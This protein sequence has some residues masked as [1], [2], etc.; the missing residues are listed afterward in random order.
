MAQQS[1][2]PAAVGAL[3]FDWLKRQVDGWQARGLVSPD[4]AS[5]ILAGY[6]PVGRFSAA[7]AA[8]GLTGLA[9]LMAA[10]A[11]LLVIG[12][13]WEALAPAAR[14]AIVFGFVGGAFAASALAYRRAR[15]WLGEALAFAATLLYGNGIFLLAGVFHIRTHDPDGLFWWMAGTLVTAVLLESRLIAITAMALLLVWV[16]YEGAEYA[17]PN[18]WFLPAAA[19][20][21][22]LAVRLRWAGLLGVTAATTALWV[23]VTA[24]FAFDG[25]MAAF[26]PVLALGAAC[27]SVG[28]WGSAPHPGSVARALR[29]AQ[30]APSMS[31]GGGPIAPLRTLALR[32]PLRAPR[33]KSRGAGRAVRGLGD[34]LEDGLGHGMIT[35][36]LAIIFVSLLPL[37]S[38]GAHDD[39]DVVLGIAWPTIAMTAVFAGVAAGL[40]AA[41]RRA[42][43]HWPILAAAAFAL[44][45]LVVVTTVDVD[46]GIAITFAVGASALALAFAIW[47]MRDGARSGSLARFAAGAAFALGFVGVRWA[48][49][50]GNLLWSALILGLAS[51]ALLWMARLWRTRP[52]PSERSE[53]NGASSTKEA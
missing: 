49:A 14:V 19:V 8:F 16:P 28:W 20:A 29:P 9:V 25:G 13:N 50:V 47:L 32:L 33:A 43:A 3:K 35:A 38:V 6:S 21:A 31:R 37:M 36:G 17:R 41:R 15:P 1:D 22:W 26:G 12:Y 34:G 7:R 46:R 18:Y 2:E 11:V 24:A 5:R 45:W 30:G 44:V 10:V 40:P 48:S 42:R 27:V 23:L 4:Q 39:I 53:S 52:A 51:A